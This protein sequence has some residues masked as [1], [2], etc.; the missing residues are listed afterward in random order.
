MQSVRML[1]LFLVVLGSGAVVAQTANYPSKPI[2]IIVPYPPGGGNDIPARRE[3]SLAINEVETA[4][5]VSIAM[6]ACRDYG[7]SKQAADRC[8]KQVRTAVAQWRREAGRL[9]IPRSEQALMAP[10]FDS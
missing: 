1:L 10:A 6:D 3:L 9:G 5:D 2:K 7:L 8:L 4:C